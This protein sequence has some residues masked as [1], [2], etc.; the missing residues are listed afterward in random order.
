MR[1]RTRPARRASRS[2]SPARKAL[3]VSYA[4]CCFPIPDD[5]IIGVPVQRPRHRDP[6]RRCSNLADYRKQPDKWMPVTW[7][8]ASKP[9]IRVGDPR[10]RLESRGRAGGGRRGVS[11]RAHQH[12]PRASSNATATRPRSRFELKVRDRKHLAQVVRSIRTMPGVRARSRASAQLTTEER[13]CHGRK[14]R[15]SHL[16]APAA[17]GPYSPGRARRQHGLSVGA[18]PARSGHDG[19]SSKAT[20]EPQMRQVFDNLT[21]VAEAAGGSL[22]NAVQL[23]VYLTDLAQLS[24]TSTRSWRSTSSEPYPARAAIG[25]APLPRGARRRGRRAFSYL[26]GGLNR[27]SSLAIAVRAA[28]HRA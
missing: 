17:I 18:D 20:F 3:V 2:R 23:T 25:V 12:R 19:S 9:T 4:R 11:G 26:I 28:G 15:L 22:A 7:R 24:R 5:P 8:R 16:K 6:P 27:C 10:R 14:N 13:S 21:A 1:R